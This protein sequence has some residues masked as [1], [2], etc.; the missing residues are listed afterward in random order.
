M[1]VGVY[2]QEEW[3]ELHNDATLRTRKPTI[4]KE[5]ITKQTAAST[6]EEKD[7]T[8]FHLPNTEVWL[9]ITVA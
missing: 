1:V 9:R 2:I 3:T 8:H 4:Q 5:S 7:D 6:E